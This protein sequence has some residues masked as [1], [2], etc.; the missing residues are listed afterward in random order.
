[1]SASPLRRQPLRSFRL[2][3]IPID[4]RV[5]ACRVAAARRVPDVD[6]TPEQT[7]LA[8]LRSDFWDADDV[9]TATLAGL[10]KVAEHPSGRLYWIPVEAWEAVMGP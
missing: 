7:L 6:I 8:R 5:R 4:L 10:R 2:A 1:M 3:D 9:D